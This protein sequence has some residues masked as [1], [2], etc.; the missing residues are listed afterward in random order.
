MVLGYE[1][2][3]YHLGGVSWPNGSLNM[4]WVSGIFFYG[5]GI[6]AIIFFL[7]NPRFITHQW[8]NYA[9]GHF[10]S[11]DIPYN[12]TH[13]FYPG[14]MRVIGPWFKGSL[15]KL[16]HGLTNLVQVLAGA[17]HSFYRVS[18]TPLYLL[19]VTVLALAWMV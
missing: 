12:Y 16:E 8:D 7:G 17:F 13:N 4:L 6:G 15:V 9:G 1:S 10:L 2:L 3:V 19:V 18:Y 14:V 11:S 5:V